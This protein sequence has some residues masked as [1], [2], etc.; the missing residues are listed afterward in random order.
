MWKKRDKYGQELRPGDVCI[1][2]IDDKPQFVVY[3]KEVFG[4]KGSKGEFGRFITEDGLRT[5]KFTSVVFAYDPMGERVVKHKKIDGLVRS[6]YEG[7]NRKD[8]G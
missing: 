7:Q 6:F 1:R 2:S 5:I 4:G 3:K 8:Q